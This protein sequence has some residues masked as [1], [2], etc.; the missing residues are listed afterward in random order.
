[1]SQKC[2]EKSNFCSHKLKAQVNFLDRNLTVSVI[3]AIVQSA[4]F[5]QT[6]HKNTW[7]REFVQMKGHTFFS[8]GR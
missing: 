6:W 2:K 8:K 7:V 1:M 5:I 3:L 4:N